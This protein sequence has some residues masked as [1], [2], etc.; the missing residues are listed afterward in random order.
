MDREYQ[1]LFVGSRDYHGFLS[2][3]T[4]ECVDPFL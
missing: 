1:Y 4:G 3:H 2:H